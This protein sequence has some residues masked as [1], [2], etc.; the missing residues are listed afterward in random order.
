MAR[1]TKKINQFPETI[2]LKLPKGKRDTIKKLAMLR[3]M[4]STTWV[5]E[6]IDHYIAYDKKRLLQEDDPSV[7]LTLDDDNELDNA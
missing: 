3:S 2:I 6:A 7:P 4:P 5:R 1:P